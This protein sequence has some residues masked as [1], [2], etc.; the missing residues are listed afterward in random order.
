MLLFSFEFDCLTKRVVGVFVVFAFIVKRFRVFRA[1]SNN[2]NIYL[3]NHLIA[4]QLT[5]TSSIKNV[6]RGFFIK[7]TFNHPAQSPVTY[8]KIS[9]LFYID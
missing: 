7:L 6:Y 5:K 8:I 1:A 3:I 2:L 4:A 9:L